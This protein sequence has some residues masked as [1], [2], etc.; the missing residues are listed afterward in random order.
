MKYV[1]KYICTLCNKE[2]SS[3]EKI[4]TCEDC[5]EKGILD[6]IYDYKKLKQKINISYFKNNKDYS[7]FRYKD[8]LP[9][10]SDLNKRALKVGYTPLY[11]A[12]NLSDILN[13]E[14][15][16]IKDEGLNPTASL[17]DRASVIATIKAIEVGNNTISCSSTGN[18]ASS[19]AGNAAR[20]G[21]KTVIFVPKRAPKAKIAQLL[22]YGAK[23]II[24]NGDY[25]QTFELSKKAIEHYGWYNRNAAIN[26]FMV[27]GKK[28]V[29]MEIAEQLNWDV[30][31]WVVVSVGDGCTIA[32]VYKGFC[33]FLKVGLIKKIPKLLGVQATGCCPF[34]TAF[35]ENKEIEP[36]KENTIADS[37]SVG[38]PRNSIKAMNAVKKSK[39][40]WISVTDQEI[41]NSIKLLGSSEGIFGEPAGVA[42]LAGL[43]KAIK[44][45]IIKKEEKICI[46]ITGNGLKDI[47]SAFKIVNKPIE[48]NADIDT[49]IAKLDE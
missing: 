31:D 44:E 7:M 35:I 8:F 21:L 6:V 4:Y 25:R 33:D 16:Y 40:T 13:I 38:I 15:L 10:K 43:K 2:Y 34:Y 27:E 11:S 28:T 30:P 14:N 20:F 41:L 29:A 37:I 1:K 47:N 9:I 23:V 49:L 26:P 22:V 42:S 45:N 19:L 3:N 18:A 24:V 12:N 39:G 48:I 5:G 36:V 32:G 46:I 17:K